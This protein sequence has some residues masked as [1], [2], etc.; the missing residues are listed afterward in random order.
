MLEVLPARLRAPIHIV[1]PFRT[2]WNSCPNLFLCSPGVEWCGMVFMAYFCPHEA[3]LW[4]DI[5]GTLGLADLICMI[6][7][8]HNYKWMHATAAVKHHDSHGESGLL[9]RHQRMW[10][11]SHGKNTARTSNKESITSMYVHTLQQCT[12]VFNARILIQFNIIFVSLFQTQIQ[13]KSN[14]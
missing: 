9:C 6:F 1:L 3:P 8:G 4:S 7:T 13:T 2:M 11:S 14:K 5:N 10:K 12:Q